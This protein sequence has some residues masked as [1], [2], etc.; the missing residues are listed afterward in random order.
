MKITK[1][2]IL[3]SAFLFLNNN[4]ASYFDSIF[5]INFPSFQFDCINSCHVFFFNFLILSSQTFIMY[6]KLFN[7]GTSLSHS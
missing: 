2:V 4:Y 3:F 1:N 7:D 6:S 5:Q